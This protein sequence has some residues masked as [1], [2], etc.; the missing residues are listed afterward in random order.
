[1]KTV[2]K[3]SYGDAEVL[4][5]LLSKELNA[6]QIFEAEKVFDDLKITTTYDSVRR[7]NKLGN[8]KPSKTESIKGKDSI[9]YKVSD[10]GLIALMQYTTSHM[11][12][13][14]Y[15]PYFPNIE[16]F[17][18]GCKKLGLDELSYYHTFVTMANHFS[19]KNE[20]GLILQR[21][22]FGKL[23]LE[24]NYIGDLKE[25]LQFYF[26]FGQFNEFLR[27]KKLLK[28]AKDSNNKIAEKIYEK[29]IPQLKQVTEIFKQDKTYWDLIKTY[30]QKF[31]ND[32]IGGMG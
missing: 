23:S 26:A 11:L 5:R 16:R 32:V 21:T 28:F 1:M 18:K 19:F 13:F 27:A 9:F 22:D 12:S 14:D 8:I 30:R 4:A 6:N 7:L 10:I 25:Q 20:Y 15:L 31:Q 3:I 2:G 24:E 29:K 17:L